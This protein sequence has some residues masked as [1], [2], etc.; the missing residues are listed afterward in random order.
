MLTINT[1]KGNQLRSINL[2]DL[3]INGTW[4]HKL[5]GPDLFKQLKKLGLPVEPS[6]GWM[7]LATVY[8]NYLADKK[9]ASQ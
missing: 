7:Q 6:F 9:E 5:P 4:A 3:P 8:G 1:Y 2:Y